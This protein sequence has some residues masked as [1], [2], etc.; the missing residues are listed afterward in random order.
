MSNYIKDSDGNDVYTNYFKY[1]TI[2]DYNFTW[3]EFLPVLL[4]Y[5]QGGIFG[6]NPTTADPKELEAIDNFINE[7]K[8]SQKIKIKDLPNAKEKDDLIDDNFYYANLNQLK[9]DKRINKFEFIRNDKE[10]TDL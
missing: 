6:H 7:I 9:N 4:H 10:N 2:G 5:I 1:L 3:Q 8:K